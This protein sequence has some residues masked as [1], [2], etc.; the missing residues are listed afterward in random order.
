MAH[1][2]VLVLGAVLVA[3][4]I[5]VP[6]TAIL[7]QDG[8]LSEPRTPVVEPTTPAP[9]EPPEVP[10]AVTS[11]TVEPPATSTAPRR[12]RAG[13]E[14]PSH[15][16]QGDS[17]PRRRPA[18]PTEPPA[19]R[20]PAPPEPALPDPPDVPEAETPETPPAPPAET[21]DPADEG[22]DTGVIPPPPLPEDDQDPADK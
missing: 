17:P 4:G 11:P 12:V 1:K 15:L 3:A 20:T 8:A 21:P 2:R 6:T 7:T 10:V 5:A 16:G 13:E 18:D 19:T 22:T 9:P 14:V